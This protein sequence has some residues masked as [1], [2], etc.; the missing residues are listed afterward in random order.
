MSRY[1]R[2]TSSMAFR[3]PG[4]A[5]SQVARQSDASLSGLDRWNFCE[6]S[7]SGFCASGEA[8]GMRLDANAARRLLVD[9]SL[10]HAIRLR[11][12][13]GNAESMAR[14]KHGTP[15]GL[16]RCE[17]EKSDWLGDIVIDG[18]HTAAHRVHLV[19]ETSPARIAQKLLP[20]LPVRLRS[21]PLLHR[22]K[23]SPIPPHHEMRREKTKYNVR[24][25][26]QETLWATRSS[27][28]NLWAYSQ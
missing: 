4:D 16:R 10:S 5:P 3:R 8:L 15:R 24:F 20:P 6:S 21:R 18:L 12:I 26:M 1:A 23:I 22:F 27:F 11:E 9:V 19:P 7:R 17:C 28:S 14:R 13:T 25:E 2:F